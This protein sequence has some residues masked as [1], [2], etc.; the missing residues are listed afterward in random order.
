MRNTPPV[1]QWNR[2]G[3]GWSAQ[4][5]SSLGDNGAVADRPQDG[6]TER[7]WGA[8]PWNM[9]VVVLSGIETDLACGGKL[10][11][12]CGIGDSEVSETFKET[13]GQV[14]DA[15]K[16]LWDGSSVIVGQFL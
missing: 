1:E 12:E 6:I 15:A 4:G 5:S 11:V 13:T 16:K 14:V 7:V 8:T 10:R 3:A 9:R 2:H